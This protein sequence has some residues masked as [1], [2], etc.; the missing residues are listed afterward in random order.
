MKKQRQLLFARSIFTFSIIIIF[1]III[2]NEKG[3]ELFLP[4]AEKK[5]NDYLQTN[6]ASLS[7][8][9][10]VNDITY[11]NTN[12]KAKITSKNNNHLYFYLYYSNHKIS[13][14]YQKD[15]LEGK[16]LLSYI[17]K[18]LQKDI[19]N[20]T[21]INCNIKISSTLDNYTEQV[22]KRIINE[23]N[24]LELKFYT[25]EKEI[26]IKDWNYKVI[27]KE[28][29]S[30]IETFQKRNITPKSYNIIITNNQDITN[31]IKINNLTEQFTTNIQ[32]EQI[33]NDIL[34][35]NN[36]NLL[37]QNKITYQYLN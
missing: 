18:K 8:S 24:L 37:N 16:S 6:Y 34:N 21:N 1:T 12:Y 30:L 7:N 27:T 4:K 11:K 32:N 25:I 23:D 14:T 36:S 3:G 5:F 22:K 10:K 13:D 28:L 15:Y 19:K 20:K 31:S 26:V 29:V 9:T 35:D 2:I 33:I 17:E